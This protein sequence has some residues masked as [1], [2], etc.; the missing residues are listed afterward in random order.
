VPA[1][2]V[3]PMLLHYQVGPKFVTQAV[4]SGSYRETMDRLF[5]DPPVSQEQVLHPDRFLGKDR[6]LPKAIQWPAGLSVALGEGWKANKAGPLG[7]LDFALWLDRWLGGTGGRL[8]PLA[9]MQGRM[10]SGAA[11]KAA[12]GWD[13]ATLQLLEKQGQGSAVA[14]VFA[15]DTKEDADEAAD[16][17]ARAIGIRYGKSLKDA[18]WTAATPG[19][20][21]FSYVSP[22]GPGRLS[23]RGD[24]VRWL[25]GAPAETVDAAFAALEGAGVTRHAN[26]TWTAAKPN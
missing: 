6:D 8:S 20:R 23:V 22:D 10:W 26:D 7:E 24:V 19:G 14:A 15:W 4:G 3:A 18:V 17:I 1:F 9:L 11:D 2:L 25:D 12:Q 13:G 5:K 21:L 16:A